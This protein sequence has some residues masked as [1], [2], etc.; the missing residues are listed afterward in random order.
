MA[1]STSA[2]VA[3]THG[4]R[5][6]SLSTSAGKVTPAGRNRSPPLPAP[7]APNSTKD[8]MDPAAWPAAT[9]STSRQGTG[10]S[11]I[12]PPPLEG[13]APVRRDHPERNDARHPP[14]E[15]GSPAP[16]PG[17]LGGLPRTRAAH[18]L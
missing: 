8:T 16:A 1:T 11:V 4:Q 14:D 6:R 7:D 17:T 12:R 18:R 3:R 9:T 10:R 15:P 5:R 13:S 2:A